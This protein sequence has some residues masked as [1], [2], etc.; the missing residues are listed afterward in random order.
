MSVKLMSADPELVWLCTV[1][2]CVKV[3]HG[4]PPDRNL[5][6]YDFIEVG[7]S[8]FNTEIQHA[9]PM[10]RGLSIEPMHTY[11]ERL[12]DLPLVKKLPMAVSDRDSELQLF[13]VSPDDI[14]K[15]NIDEWIKG[16][17]SIQHP[18]PTAWHYLKY[19]N[20]T[21]LMRSITVR[22]VTF[23]T[24][25]SE[26]SVGSI[27][28]LKVDTE[29]H[30]PNIIRSMVQYCEQHPGTFPKMITF[31]ANQ[32]TSDDEKSGTLGL[33]SK[34]GYVVLHDDQYD[35]QMVRCQPYFH[36]SNLL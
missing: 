21:Y 34:H 23:G 13:Y 12:P 15:H 32:L 26:H 36:K 18:H 10:T 16:C 22:S 24:L 6:H 3:S 29:G 25:V 20:L 5:L 31:E 17:N 27:G 1:T 30:D 19:F 8:D 7:T 9:H 4:P 35:V 2:L 11:L 33:L 14:A 28:H